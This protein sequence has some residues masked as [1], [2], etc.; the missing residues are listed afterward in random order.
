MNENN[1]IYITLKGGVRVT[2]NDKVI[3]WNDNHGSHEGKV[4]AYGKTAEQGGSP[5]TYQKMAFKVDCGNGEIREV[6]EGAM[7]DIV[8]A[9]E[10]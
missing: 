6:R 10:G 1:K 8:S 4:I 9:M 5:V 3:K 2:L 7:R